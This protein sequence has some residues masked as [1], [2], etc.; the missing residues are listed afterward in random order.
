MQ[1]E[2]SPL[3]DIVV[4]SFDFIPMIWIY[5]SPNTLL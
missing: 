3:A 1:L 2:I 4:M 5:V